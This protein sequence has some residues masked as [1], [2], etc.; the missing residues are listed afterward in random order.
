MISKTIGFRDTN[1]FQT[2]PFSA[3]DG[4][5]ARLVVSDSCPDWNSRASRKSQMHCAS[6]DG[7]HPLPGRGAALPTSALSGVWEKKD[8][9]GSM[10]DLLL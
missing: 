10:T 8:Q 7:H 1:H 9:K 6:G 3:R 2:N 5:S 4:H